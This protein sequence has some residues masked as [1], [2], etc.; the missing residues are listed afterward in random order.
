[1]NARRGPGVARDDGGQSTVELALALPL[2][3]LLLL[4][5]V[6]VGCTVHDQ[7]VVTHASREAARAAAVDADPRA[8]RWAAEAG[9]GLDPGRLTVVVVGRE[10]P[11]GPVTVEVRYRSPVRVPLLRLALPEVGL[12]SRTTMRVER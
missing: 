7:V 6:Q 9:G 5:V 12:A 3:V 4:L 8:P 2:L 10:G 11:G 1:M